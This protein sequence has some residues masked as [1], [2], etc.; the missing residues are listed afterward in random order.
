MP[1][2]KCGFDNSPTG[3]G[4]ELL[5]YFGP[6][7]FVDIGFDT[8]WDISKLTTPIPLITQISALVDTGATESCIDDLLATQLNLP[9]IDKRPIAGVGGQLEA[10]IYLSQI[11][12]PALRFTIY[13]YFAGVHLAAGGQIHKAIIGRTF[14]R[15]C[16]MI[17]SG[18]TGDVTITM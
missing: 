10:K 9:I 6:T 18:L 15:S 13:G 4:S 11:H 5:V 16:T 8:S 14:L 2:T 1:D 12:I 7:L 3:S 17:Y